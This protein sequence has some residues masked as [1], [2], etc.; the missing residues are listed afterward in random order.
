MT[1]P[2]SMPSVGASPWGYSPSMMSMFGANPMD[3]ESDPRF[4]P[5][6]KKGFQ[7]DPTPFKMAEKAE[8]RKYKM[9][10][11]SEKQ[12]IKQQ[13]YVF[14]DLDEN[15]IP[16]N[17]QANFDYDEYDE[18]DYDDEIEFPD[19]FALKSSERERSFLPEPEFIKDS[20]REFA[21]LDWQIGGM[22]PRGD[23]DDDLLDDYEED[24]IIEQ[25][26]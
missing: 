11:K 23:A 9:K 10:H 4:G 1:Y 16:M 7:I 18:E 26:V 22:S 13:K 19:P 3:P 2:Y 21:L 6:A 8:K 5:V 25:L 14:N 12:K 17:E 24:A 20:G 15:G